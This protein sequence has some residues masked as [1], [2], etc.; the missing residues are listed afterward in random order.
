MTRREQ[1][2][3]QYEDALF[4]LLM[5]EATQKHNE[6]AFAAYEQ[7]EQSDEIQ[8][9]PEVDEKMQQLIQQYQPRKRRLIRVNFSKM[10][11]RVAVA[12]CLISA[13]TATAFAAFPDL[14]TNV[15]NFWLEIT[16]ESTD[17]HFT[18]SDQYS[19]D[20]LT[21]NWIPEGF[22][23]ESTEEIS[24][25]ISYEYMHESDNSKHIEVIK[26]TNTSTTLTVDTENATQE[27][28]QI[29]GEYSLLVQK[30]VDGI[31]YLTLLI[32][33]QTGHFLLEITASEISKD[34]II[35]FAENIQYAQ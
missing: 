2:Q 16:E 29:N 31:D 10:I 11:S 28:L 13:L 14:K 19:T 26:Y 3:E 32:E 6:Q 35:K 22:Y 5:E 30:T 7:L 12:A 23:L 17:F 21:I 25:I 4:A 9:P 1:L 33:N 8:I 24:D 15:M 34:E 27:E 18:G 20:N